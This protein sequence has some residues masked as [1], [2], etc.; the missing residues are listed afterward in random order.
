MIRSIFGEP[1]ARIVQLGDD[2]SLRL[3][4]NS[5]DEDGLQNFGPFIQG[6]QV[7]WNALKDGVIVVLVPS[8]I[9]GV[10]KVPP[11]YWQSRPPIWLDPFSS[12][13]LLEVQSSP[14]DE[15]GGQPFIVNS[16]HLDQWREIVMAAATDWPTDQRRPFETDRMI[17]RT[18]AE[19]WYRDRVDNWSGPP[20]SRRDDEQ[21]GKAVGLGRDRVRELRKAIAP[22]SW[23]RHG[24]RTGA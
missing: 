23:Q 14:L 20:P 9:E 8:K 22:P 19:R 3:P 16:A 5:S 6:R 12:E 15:L 24:R 13:D 10:F 4:S 17:S 18:D 11:I 1:S 2:I 7:L 21:A